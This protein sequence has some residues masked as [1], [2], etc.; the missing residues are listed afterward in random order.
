[1]ELHQYLCLL[2]RHLSLDADILNELIVG[3][4][5][6]I[7]QSHCVCTRF[8]SRLSHECF[9]LSSLFVDPPAHPHQTLLFCLLARH[10]ILPK[11]HCCVLYANER[12]RV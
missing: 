9:A 11:V 12:T 10:P 6:Q 3:D 5:F 7:I 2:L 8:I 1:M 4:V